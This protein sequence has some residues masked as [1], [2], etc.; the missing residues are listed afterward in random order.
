[1][2]SG[3][4]G[5]YLFD[6]CRLR[7]RRTVCTNALTPETTTASTLVVMLMLVVDVTAV[8]VV[9]H[10]AN[11]G[12]ALLV[13]HIPI[14]M[15]DTIVDVSTMLALRHLGTRPVEAHAIDMELFVLLAVGSVLGTSRNVAAMLAGN[16]PTS[17]APLCAVMTLLGMLALAMS[18][19]LAALLQLFGFLRCILRCASIPLGLG[20][21][22]TGHPVLVTMT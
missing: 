11:M 8:L 7:Q 22:S 4:V 13:L 2:G 12:A 5:D 10:C 18:V 17:S 16:R 9:M 14:G 6:F 21:H 20:S 19:D 3:L 15:L 1:M